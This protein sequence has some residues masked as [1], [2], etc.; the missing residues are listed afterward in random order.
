[1]GA[2]QPLHLVRDPATILASLRTYAPL[3]DAGSFIATS[4]LDRTY[5]C[6]AWAVGISSGNWWPEPDAEDEYFWPDGALRDGSVEA[7]LD[8]YSRLGFV[9]CENAELEPG[10]YKI[11]VFST[12]LGSPQHVARQ[13]PDGRWASKMGELE[14]IEHASLRDLS[15]G[16][17]GL[18]TRFMKV[19]TA[20]T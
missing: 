13:L 8:G 16:R 6:A 4:D 18:P 15:Q 12:R 17:Y 7:I 20:T 14:D 10:V 3:L 5:N 19:P 11:A 2:R 9:V 1:M